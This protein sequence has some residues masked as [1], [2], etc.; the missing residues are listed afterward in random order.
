MSKPASTRSAARLAAVQALFQMELSGDEAP[1]VIT[2]F[3][4]HRYE[5]A[6]DGEALMKPDDGFFKDLVLGVTARRDD[7]DQRI[8]A[9]LASGWSLERIDKLVLQVLRAA[10]YELIARPDVPAK[11]TISEYLDVTH[12]FHERTEANFVNGL[13]D[14]LARDLGRVSA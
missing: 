12:A 4:H 10:A 14:R 3:R 7:L 11:V 13:L 6:V 5:D 9:L 2:E 8:S 1:K